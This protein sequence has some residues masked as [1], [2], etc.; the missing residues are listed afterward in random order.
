MRGLTN[1]AIGR[2][3]GIAEGTAELHV[4]G[5]RGVVARTQRAVRADRSPQPS[6]L[7]ADAPAQRAGYG[8]EGRFEGGPQ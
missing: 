4:A 3:L 7:R 6:V 5:E 2:Q 8:A 1:A